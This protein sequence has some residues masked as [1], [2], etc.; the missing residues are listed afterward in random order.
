MKAAA[1]RRIQAAEA[2]QAA[3]TLGLTAGVEPI[4]PRDALELELWRTHLLVQLYEALVSELALGEGGIYG[5]TMHANGSPT[6][7]G[8]PHVLV[9]M[10]DR[11]RHHLTLVAI[12]AAKAGVEQRRV[13]LEESHA[14]LV[15]DLIRTVIEDPELGLSRE[16]R[17]LALRKAAGGLRLISGG[18][19]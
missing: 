15:A 16:H 7:E 5:R 14:R 18:A 11:E 4:D 1:G 6:G 3:L 9:Q 12:A 10:R 2:H 17:Q 13:E 19:G 8:K